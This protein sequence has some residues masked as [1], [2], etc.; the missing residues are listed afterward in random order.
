MKKKSPKCKM[1]Y[2]FPFQLN[3]SVC[4]QYFGGLKQ[5]KDASAAQGNISVS[6]IWKQANVG[7]SSSTALKV[8]NVNVKYCDSLLLHL[9]IK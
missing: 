1:Y 4:S 7:M 5:K 6:L 2:I 8:S 9:S 3:F